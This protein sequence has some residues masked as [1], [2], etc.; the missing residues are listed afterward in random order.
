[1]GTITKQFRLFLAEQFKELFE[2]TPGDHV[3]VFIGHPTPWTDDNN[4]PVS[5]DTIQNT[6]YNIWS[7]I[8][9]AKIIAPS[10]VTYAANR[11]NWTSGTVYN[12]YTANTAFHDGAFFVLTNDY[13]VYKCI[14]N[15]NGTASTVQPFGRLTTTFKTS[16]GYKWKFMCEVPAADAVKYITT[17]FIPVKVLSS[18]DGSFQYD[19]QSAAV[20]GSIETIGV[21]SGGTGYQS[22]TG[23]LQSANSTVMTLA[24]GANTTSGVY[25]QSSIYIDS[26]AGLGQLKKISN[27]NGPSQKVTVDSAFSPAP[28]ATS[29]YIIGPTINVTGDGTGLKAYSVV[30]DG[31]ISKVNVINIG[32]NYGKASITATANSSLG[33]G[34]S[35]IA[36]L[37]PPG[38]HG[39]NTVA[40]LY[41]HNVIMSIK[42]VGSE[43]GTVYTNND[44]RVVGVIKNPLLANNSVADSVSYLVAPQLEISS[45]IG[46][47]IPDEVIKGS[48]SLTEATF[49][50]YANTNTITIS[51]ETANFTTETITG[52]T[53]LATAT[54][55]SVRESPL[56]KYTG[57]VLYYENRTPVV[58]SPF[59]EEDF[60]IILSL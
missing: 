53:S 11:Y 16:D 19:V 45:M 22:H 3:Y 15:N 25:T 10:D 20:N 40:E 55:T 33:S 51:G 59:Q 52:Q 30:T 34:A 54:I 43:E 2:E 8:D 35:F 28:D 57:Q 5:D 29:T 18:D 21:L 42:L 48:T 31:S 7:D 50:E 36:H 39:A 24:T 13:N 38:G 60:R 47:F 27:Y 49:V 37:S 4:P 14:D 9:S 44:F 12:Q 56:K 26:G 17:N 32:E 46:T 58:R 41:G 6:V 23:T 1:M